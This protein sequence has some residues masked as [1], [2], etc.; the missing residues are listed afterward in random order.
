MSGTAAAPYVILTPRGAKLWLLAPAEIKASL[1]PLVGAV[2]EVQGTYL[3]GSDQMNVTSI[4]SPAPA[5]MN[6]AT[7]TTQMPSSEPAATGTAK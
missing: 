4:V 7:T 5:M 2:V 3:P 6:P 1:K